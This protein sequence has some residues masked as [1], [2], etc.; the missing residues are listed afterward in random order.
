MGARVL[1]V[2]RIETRRVSEA[3]ARTNPRRATPRL[4]LTNVSGYHG[5]RGGQVDA[6]INNECV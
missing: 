6:I 2:P 4:S 1:L 5:P 3:E